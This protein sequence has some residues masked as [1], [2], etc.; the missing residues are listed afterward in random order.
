M[1]VVGRTPAS[2]LRYSPIGVH[3]TPYL[4]VLIN[5]VLLRRIG[6]DQMASDLK[7]V[8]LRLYPRLSDGNIPGHMLTTFQ[9][10][11]ELA[12]DTMVFQPYRQ[13]A[14]KSLAQLANFGPREIALIEQAGR[15]LAA[16]QDPGTVPVR[17]MVSAARFALDNRLAT[18]QAITD[19]FY[20]T[21][22][23]R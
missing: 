14:G 2:T 11:S 12:V 9:P 22:G 13:F 8:W 18:P 4:R 3:P 1:D 15:R 7:R 5:L 23:R 19:N 10:A 17:F 6:F 21:L 16:G 20:R